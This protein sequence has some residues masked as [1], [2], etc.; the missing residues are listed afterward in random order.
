MK[1][2]ISNDRNNELKGLNSGERLLNP[3]DNI[4]NHIRREMKRRVLRQTQ[5]E[6]QHPPSLGNSM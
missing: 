4:H 1:G 5:R 3:L 2:K 6:V